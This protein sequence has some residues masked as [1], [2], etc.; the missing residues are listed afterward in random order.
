[1]GSVRA[2]HLCADRYKLETRGHVVLTDQEHADTTEIGPTPLELLVMAIVGS[3]ARQAVRYVRERGLANDE[4]RVDAVWSTVGD[5]TRVGRIDLT[6]T[7]SIWLTH[8][9]YVA[10]LET[11]KTGTVMN[12]LRNPP[13]ID[14]DV[15][16]RQQA[17][18]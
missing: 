13:V 14:I 8:E 1:M 11:V 12:T 3:A 5:P 9:D 2:T 18:S 6:F 16:V 4:L 7:P 17:G 10:M 15:P